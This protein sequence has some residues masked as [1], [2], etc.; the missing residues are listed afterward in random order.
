PYSRYNFVVAPDRALYNCT[1]MN[2][3]FDSLSSF[4]DDSSEHKS[5]D[6]LPL[7]NSGVQQQNSTVSNITASSATGGSIF[8]LNPPASGSS[9]SSVDGTNSGVMV[10]AVAN[11]ATTTQILETQLPDSIVSTCIN[12]IHN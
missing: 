8:N 10:S 12:S 5:V 3:K 1:E 7:S 6:A 4:T 11:V 2:S 9:V